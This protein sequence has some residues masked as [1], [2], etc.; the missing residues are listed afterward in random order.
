MHQKLAQDQLPLLGFGDPTCKQIR[1]HFRAFLGP[2][3]MLYWE[4][5][6]VCKELRKSK[7]KLFDIPVVISAD[8]IARG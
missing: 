2:Q 5:I 1:F 3:C 4:N 6:K 7:S 8:F